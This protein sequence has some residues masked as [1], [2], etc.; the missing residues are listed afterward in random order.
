MITCSILSCATESTVKPI[1]LAGTCSIYSKNAITPADQYCNNPWLMIQRLQMRTL[2]KS[3]KDIAQRQKD[4]DVPN[5]T[6]VINCILSMQN[7]RPRP[8]GQGI[9]VV[10]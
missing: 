8:K 7:E 1:R 2:G 4:D 6:H 9:R 10:R 5:L 3:H